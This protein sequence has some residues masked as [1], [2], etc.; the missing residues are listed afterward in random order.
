MEN[1]KTLKSVSNKKAKSLGFK[2]KDVSDFTQEYDGLDRFKYTTDVF[3]YFFV[4]TAINTI[5]H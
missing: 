3:S 1:T 2:F 4:K 5:I